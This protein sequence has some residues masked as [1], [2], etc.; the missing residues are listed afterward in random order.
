MDR[1]LH[2]TGAC[3]ASFGL[4]GVQGRDAVDY[5]MAKNIGVLITLSLEASL[6]VIVVN[7]VL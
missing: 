6:R 4:L 2:G 7:Q 3:P 1:L 5:V